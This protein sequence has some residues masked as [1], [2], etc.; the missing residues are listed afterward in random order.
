MQSLCQ[1]QR[2]HFPLI[3]VR[4][5]QLRRHVCTI[6]FLRVPLHLVKEKAQRPGFPV[7]LAHTLDYCLVVY[8]TSEVDA[9]VERFEQ[10]E[11]VQLG[12]S[13]KW[14]P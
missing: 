14:P 7:T 2:V 10:A 12:P 1:G 4:F 11:Q 6:D 8:R 9:S 5:T 3:Q 13:H